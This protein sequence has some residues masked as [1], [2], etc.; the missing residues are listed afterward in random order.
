MSSVPLY[1]YVPLPPR[2][3]HPRRRWPPDAAWRRRR[4]CRLW[5]LQERPPAE[6]G[7]GDGAGS[8]ALFRRRCPGKGQRGP[9][10]GNGEAIPLKKIIP[11]LN[12]EF[13]NYETYNVPY[14][15]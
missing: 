3:S 12:F 1:C 6:E 9:G 13:L 5:H 4:L 15:I 14:C 8:H 10:S 7:K 11:L 2:Y